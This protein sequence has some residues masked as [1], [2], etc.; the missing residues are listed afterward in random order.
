MHVIELVLLK[1]GS[2]HVV[3]ISKESIFKVQIVFLGSIDCIKILVRFLL[4]LKFDYL[5]NVRFIIHADPKSIILG[6]F[7]QSM[8]MLSGFKSLCKILKLSRTLNPYTKLI[9]SGSTSRALFFSVLKH[10]G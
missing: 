7:L 10:F 3:S 9:I 8:R 5:R 4:M 1:L 2:S 6:T